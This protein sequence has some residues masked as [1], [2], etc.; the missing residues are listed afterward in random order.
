M[1]FSFLICI[2]IFS[3]RLGWSQ[4]S[5]L[6]SKAAEINDDYVE[7]SVHI[8]QK[9]KRKPEVK[10]RAYRS[11]DQK[12][13]RQSVPRSTPEVLQGVEGVYIQQTSHGQASA[14]VRGR[15]GRHT[16]LMVD[17][18]RLNHALFRQGPNQYLFTVDPFLLGQ[19]DVVR[20]GASVRLGAN[21]LSGAILT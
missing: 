2:N 7:Q 20:G 14:Y 10:G 6:P 3:F 13:I 8:K 16:L 21:A 17:G 12:E 5:P 18:F 9:K 19:I 1:T 15:T 11:L 4:D